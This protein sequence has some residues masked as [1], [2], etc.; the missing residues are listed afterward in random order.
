MSLR[1]SPE[2]RHKDNVLFWL[3]KIYPTLASRGFENVAPGYSNEI[4]AP[5]DIATGHSYLFK[6]PALQ[7]LNNFDIAFIVNKIHKE[8]IL[9]KRLT[10][11]APAYAPTPVHLLQMG[12]MDI[13]IVQMHCAGNMTLEKAFYLPIDIF[14]N[15]E[16]ALVL[17]QLIDCSQLCTLGRMLTCDFSNPANF[18]ITWHKLGDVPHIKAIDLQEWEHNDNPVRLF[19][20]NES[21]LKDLLMYISDKPNGDFGKCVTC[22]L[23]QLNYMTKELDRTEVLNLLCPYCIEQFPH[24]TDQLRHNIMQTYTQTIQPI[25]QHIT[26]GQ[27][28]FD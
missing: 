15:A 17:L 13:P 12:G 7:I 10:L 6:Y 22:K 8:A 23:K 14:T 25:I 21:E 5:R 9:L 27:C 20:I 19:K 4:W 16:R 11:V 18:M 24:A 28:S 26:S 1:V 3:A 2:A